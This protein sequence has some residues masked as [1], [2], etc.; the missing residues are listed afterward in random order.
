MKRQLGLEISKISKLIFFFFVI[1]ILICILGPLI[2]FS[3]LNP[4][5]EDNPIISGT[6][7]INLVNV[8][9]NLNVQFY[10]SS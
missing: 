5:A 9:T 6:F 1:V 7:T 10:E 3:A 8:D 4:A 2:L